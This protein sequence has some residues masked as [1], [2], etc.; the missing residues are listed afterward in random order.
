MGND[1]HVYVLNHL[2]SAFISDQHGR[3]MNIPILTKVTD[4]FQNLTRPRDIILSG[5]GH[6]LSS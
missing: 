3:K 5:C 6:I 4:L 2:Q 1:K